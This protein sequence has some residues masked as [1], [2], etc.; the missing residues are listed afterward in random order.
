MGRRFRRPVLQLCGVVV[1][2]V[3]LPAADKG[4]QQPDVFDDRQKAEEVNKNIVLPRVKVKELAR[5]E[6]VLYCIQGCAAKQQFVS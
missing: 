4:Y 5:C 1:A 6:G 3:L 2:A